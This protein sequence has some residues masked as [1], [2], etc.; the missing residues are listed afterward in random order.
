MAG[1]AASN[2][3]LGID[4]DSP[5]VGRDA[6][7]ARIQSVWQTVLDGKGRLVLLSGE[8][9]IGKTRLAEEVLLRTATPKCVTLIGRCFEQ[10]SSIPFFPFTEAFAAAWKVAP[11]E[12]THAAAERWQELGFIVPDVLSPARGAP[13]SVDSEATQL[14]VFQCATQFLVRFAEIQPI[15]LLLDDLHWADATSLGLLL[16]LVRHLADER[17]L[18]VGTYRDIDVG[19]QHPLDECLRELVRERI[20][21]EIHL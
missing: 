21:D 9:G 2:Q 7:L 4:V 15:V 1:I 20:V 18:I 8:P 10:Q 19:R 6:E 17:L 3:P 12:L 13:T 5:L 11:T 14:R 16:Y